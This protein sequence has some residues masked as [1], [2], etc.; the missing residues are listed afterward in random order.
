MGPGVAPLVGAGAAV[1]VPAG[2]DTQVAFGVIA[3]V[4]SRTASTGAVAI[5]RID[6]RRGMQRA[7]WEPLIH[8]SECN[9]RTIR[10]I[11]V[12]RDNA[13][14]GDVDAMFSEARELIDDG[15]SPEDVLQDVFGLEPDYILD[16][17]FLMNWL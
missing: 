2:L 8:L 10:Q 16:D 15:E 13:T 4:H 5:G 11:I 6:A 1:P 3:G 9:M 12:E 7:E 14:P 17:E